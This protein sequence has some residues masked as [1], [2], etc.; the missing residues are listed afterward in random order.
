MKWESWQAFWSMGGDA[1][2]VW[3]S[4]GVALL[5]I[6]VELLSLIHRRKDTVKRLLRW[7]R[8]TTR[9]AAPSGPAGT[10]QLRAEP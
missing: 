10:D 5:A 8:A 6:V 3:G 7:K 9:P 1:F 4:Y 2:F